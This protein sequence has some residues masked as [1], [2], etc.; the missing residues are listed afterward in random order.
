MG[1]RGGQKQVIR[2]VQKKAARYPSLADFSFLESLEA[3]AKRLAHIVDSGWVA[4]EG[5]VDEG[6]VQCHYVLHRH[7]RTSLVG[8]RGSMTLQDPF[9]ICN[10][11]HSLPCLSF[12][13]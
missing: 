9:S 11:G 5:Q 3:A 8:C 6:G 10:K 7:R 4:L 13:V 1:E 12:V 2:G